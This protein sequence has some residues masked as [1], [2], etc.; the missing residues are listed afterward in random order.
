MQVLGRRDELPRIAVIT[1][2]SAPLLAAFAREV[3]L[4]DA[5]LYGDPERRLY[6][7]LGFGRGSVARVWLDPRVWAR[8]GRLVLGGA[9]LPRRIE[10]DTLQL[11]GDVLV[12]ADGRVAWLYRSRGP[13]DRPPADELVRQVRRL[14]ITG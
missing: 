3:E 9:R 7:A 2:A 14:F 6:E 12:D 5:S 4:Q 11:G 10:Q 13:D 8:Y 1:F